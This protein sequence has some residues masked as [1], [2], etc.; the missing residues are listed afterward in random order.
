M[1]QRGL[2]RPEFASGTISAATRDLINSRGGSSGGLDTRHAQLIRGG[3]PADAAK[4]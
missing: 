1:F 4:P 3:S 2:S